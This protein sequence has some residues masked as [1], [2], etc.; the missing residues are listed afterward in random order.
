MIRLIRLADAECI[1][2][3]SEISLG[4]KSE[5][6]IVEKQILKFKDNPNHI[7]IVYEDEVVHKVVGYI[8][9]ESYES[10]YN[11]GGINILALA[12][13]PQYQGK[14]IGKELIAA[15]EDK[16]R[17]KG[18]KFIRFNSSEKRIDAHN[19][20]L[21]MGYNCDKLQKRFSKLL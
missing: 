16:A 7:I 8:H 3:I 14:G 2:N 9:A 10:L 6:D 17:T 18:V 20:Y 12:V 5:L 1:K 11:S 13:L 19:F 4:Y 15:F 21:R